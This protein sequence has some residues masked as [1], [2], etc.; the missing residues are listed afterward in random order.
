MTAINF[1][2]DADTVVIAMDT[3]SISED[4]TPFKF[5]SK[6]FPLP[7]LRSVM[8]GTG[9]LDLILE[10]YT[11]IQKNVISY[12]IDIFSQ[13]TSATLKKLNA[14]HPPEAT[15]TIYQFGY[16]HKQKSFRGFVYRSTNEFASEEYEYCTAHKP[17][18]DF[19]FF[20]EAENHGLDEAFIKLITLQK[21]EDDA[22]IDRVGIGGEIHKFIMT[23]DSYHLDTIHRFPDHEEQYGVMV[24]KLNK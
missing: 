4:R 19:D 11:T 18:V 24:D 16:S 20:R 23:R 6:I 21:L 17:Q 1:M 12:D 5:V 10:W 8:C 3:L 9:N 22:S 15:T 13:L 7:H 14:K 2:F